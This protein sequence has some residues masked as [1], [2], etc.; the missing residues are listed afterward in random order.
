MLLPTDS[1]RCD[2]AATAARARATRAWMGCALAA[3]LAL[4]AAP[5][6][7]LL[8]PPWLWPV[9]AAV[10]SLLV[11]LALWAWYRVARFHRVLVRLDLSPTGLVATDAAGRRRTWPWTG[12]LAVNL[13]AEGGTE[14]VLTSAHGAGTCLRIGPEWPGADALARRVVRYAHAYR[15]PLCVHG[16]ACDALS[17]APLADVLMAGRRDPA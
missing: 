2:A 15:R 6:A 12:V 5:L 13:P 11:G 14:I 10:A 8:P 7:P 4:A 1:F 16:V 17:L 9:V 3:G